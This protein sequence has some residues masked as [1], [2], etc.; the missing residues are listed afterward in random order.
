M[1]A[2]SEELAV[3]EQPLNFPLYG[4]FLDLKEV[5]PDLVGVQAVAIYGKSQK[6]SVNTEAAPVA[7]SSLTTALLTSR[8][9]RTM[10]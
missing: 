7:A 10:W 1:L 3:A 8:L 9:I 4:A 5:R 2:Q 6:L